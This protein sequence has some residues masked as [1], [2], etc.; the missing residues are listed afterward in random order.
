MLV[1]LI[2]RLDRLSYFIKSNSWHV[3]TNFT[4]LVV[5][6]MQSKRILDRELI[7]VYFTSDSLIM[8]R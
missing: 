5:K 3:S 4:A 1:N 8:K 2:L 6:V 7:L